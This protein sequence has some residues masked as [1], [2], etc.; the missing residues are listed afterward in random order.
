MTKKQ[1]RFNIDL[2]IEWLK[3]NNTTDHDIRKLIE[4]HPWGMYDGMTYEEVSKTETYLLR[5][6]FTLGGKK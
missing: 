1:I 6:W 5:E 3:A 2:F 4:E